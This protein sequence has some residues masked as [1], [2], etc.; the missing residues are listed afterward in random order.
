MG[1]VRNLTP[2]EILAQFVIASRV[3][4]QSQKMPPLT[5][6]VFMGMVPTQCRK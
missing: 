6:I 1:L 5:N 3:A 4:A 2:D